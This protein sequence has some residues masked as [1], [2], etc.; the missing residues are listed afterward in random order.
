[1]NIA[2]LSV[3][4]V[5][6]NHTN[7]DVGRA[8]L[9]ALGCRVDVASNGY[10][11]LDRLGSARYDIIFMDCQM[12]LM[13]GLEATR[14]VRERE[15][16]QGCLK[17]VIVALTADGSD[18]DR[19]RCLDAGMDD[20]MSKPFRMQDLSDMIEKW[21]GRMC[22][23]DSAVGSKKSVSNSKSSGNGGG[24]FLDR[25][26]LDNLRSLGPN[27]PK[28]LSNIIEIYLI[29]SPILLDRL[30]ETFNTA[31]ADGVA[32]AAHSLKSTSAG[33]GA[34][35]LAATC[36]QLE[37]MARG[38]SIDGADTLISRIRSQYEKVR[39]ALERELREDL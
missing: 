33:L 31:D 6:D 24:D 4:L 18:E 1:M 9:E 12:P 5:E 17:A 2:N 36:K 20:H 35:V 15:N 16:R 38:N 19:L 27:G 30:N 3:L 28:M 39:V 29:D 21:C 32:R 7:Q 22:D 13:D 26:S 25:R 11:V 23:P 8:M 34:T 14:S 37:D 10:E